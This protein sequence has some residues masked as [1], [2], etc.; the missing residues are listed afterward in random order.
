MK[1]RW[2][3]IALIAIIVICVYPKKFGG[4]LCGPIC[5][6]TGLQTEKRQCMGFEMRKNY[7]D[8]FSDLCFGI[9]YGEKT[10][11]GVPHGSMPNTPLTKLPCGYAPSTSTNDNS[12]GDFIF[13]ER[14]ISRREGGDDIGY[15]QTIKIWTS[16][17]AQYSG[18][19]NK[20]LRLPVSAVNQI[21]KLITDTGV[22]TKTCEAKH[23]IAD[24]Q[25]MYIFHPQEKTII[26]PACEQELDQIDK[27]IEQ[28]TVSS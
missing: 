19:E 9:P 2:I 22:L 28:L 27:L 18:Q 24:G 10:C 15:S 1:K 3:V 8:G 11:Y 14:H 5:P 12:A 16:G 6:A 23:M 17:L 21:D 25:T 4:P 20:E 13:F 7:I 26:Y